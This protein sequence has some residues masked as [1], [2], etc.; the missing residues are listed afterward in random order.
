MTTLPSITL[1]L[2]NNSPRSCLFSHLSLSSILPSSGCVR[3]DVDRSLR[4]VLMLTI[5]CISS[6][7]SHLTIRLG[8]CFTST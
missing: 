1:G 8:D 5:S 3:R 2:F 6:R 7:P 4:F